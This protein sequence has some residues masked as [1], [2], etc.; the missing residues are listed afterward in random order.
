MGVP[1]RKE[2]AGKS[3]I[4]LAPASKR[5]QEKLNLPQKMSTYEKLAS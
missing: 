5:A 2:H 3:V 4:S 1:P